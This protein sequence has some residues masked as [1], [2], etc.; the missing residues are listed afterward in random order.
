MDEE[1]YI[2]EESNTEEDFSCLECIYFTFCCWY[3]DNFT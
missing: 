3:T 1:Q 2:L